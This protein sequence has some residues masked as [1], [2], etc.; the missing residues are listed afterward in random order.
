MKTPMLRLTA[1][2]PF[3][4]V[5]LAACG[6]DL[7]AP[8]S[9]PPPAVNFAPSSGV[10]PLPSDLLYSGTTDLTLSIPGV[11]DGSNPAATPPE[12]ALS[13][14]DGWST[15]APF[16]ISF[17]TP[18]DALTVT[19]GTTVRLFEV[20]LD[21]GVSLVGGPVDTVV[22]EL[23]ATTDFTVGMAPEVETNDM[24]IRIYLEKPLKPATSYM[25]VLTNGITDMDGT[26]CE[27][28][29]EYLLASS[30]VAF[31]PGA[32]I[33]AL[34]GLVGAQLAAAVGEG[35]VRDDII[36]TNVFTTQGVDQVLLTF[37]AISAGQ[38]AAVIAALCAGL[39][40]GCVGEGTA[41]DP[42][43][44]SSLLVNMPSVI[45]TADALGAGP[46]LADIYTG[47]LA[48]PYYLT[49]VANPSDTAGVINTDPLT[50]RIQARFNFLPAPLVDDHHVTSTNVL[51][52]T[53]ASEVI[54]VLI[55]VPNVASGQAKPPGGWPVVVFQHGITGNRTNMLA[56]AD[57][58]AFAGIMVVAIDLPLHGYT[59]T[60]DPVI[61]AGYDAAQP[62]A[63]ERIFG[64][65]LLDAL[66]AAGP[67]GTVD[68]SGSHFINLTNLLVTRD[69]L[70]QASSDLLH[71]TSQLAS[72]DYDGGGADVDAA[73]FHFVGH[74]LGGIVGI[75]FLRLASGN[76]Q[77]AT[78]AMP[79]GGIAKLLNGSD[80]FGPRIRAGLAA[81]GVVD[82][83]ADFEGFLWAAQTAIDSVD[84]I[85]HAATLAASGLPI[86]FIEVVGGG[87][88]GGL[89]DAVVPNSVALAPLAG[90]EPTITALGLADIIVDTVNGGGIQGVVR[91]IEGD[92][93]SIL[94]PT[95]NAAAFTEMQTQTVEFVVT[96]GT[97]LTLV[98]ETVIDTTP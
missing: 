41:V 36:M 37:A 65:D 79:G 33:A 56:I 58:F 59:T 30:L 3:A 18:L 72:L 75:P 60:A 69:N 64:L 27:K 85:N 28:V 80:S 74:S 48:V 88:G 24:S 43:N 78:L 7:K 87:A 12:I 22:G 46:G 4:L 82:G 21:T 26:P 47:D 38:E 94:D 53:T 10:V 95:A 84:P 49:G 57:A 25:W 15:S 42:N 73:R 14:M 54:P 2:A 81:A 62:G 92:H 50:E 23:V 1:T 61:F 44:T 8:A 29:G 89:P 77:S 96:S 98:D 16:T 93:S 91:F 45:T 97:S 63:R 19:A 51:A 31:D 70:R 13:A 11:D 35:M 52:A 20:T 67:D 90:S 40:S 86:H 6:S 17:N 9:V 76:F 68:P 66:G 71:L 5:F 83:T 55:A 32:P 34:Q 39:P